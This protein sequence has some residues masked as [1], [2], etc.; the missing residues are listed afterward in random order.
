ML[1]LKKI[2]FIYWDLKKLKWVQLINALGASWK[3][4]EKE[5]ADLITPSIYDRHLIKNNQTFSPNKVSGREL[6]KMEIIKSNEKPTFK[7]Y[8]NSFLYVVNLDMS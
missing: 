2:F 4:Q 6:Y 5:K 1:K 3:K 8:C 7:P